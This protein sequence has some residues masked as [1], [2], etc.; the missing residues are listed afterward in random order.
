MPRPKFQRTH[1]AE[2]KGVAAMLPQDPH[3]A[4]IARVDSVCRRD[5][6]GESHRKIAAIRKPPMPLVE[7]RKRSAAKKRQAMK[8]RERVCDFIVMA[9]DLA[10][11]IHRPGP[12]NLAPRS[13][14]KVT[15]WKIFGDVGSS[16]N[17]SAIGLYNG[18]KSEESAL[19]IARAMINEDRSSK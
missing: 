7:F 18:P 5:D 11:P 13:A 14:G 2:L 16:A 15:A 3:T 10:N 4:K 19:S 12:K 9:I 6:T 8:V 1:Q 17:A